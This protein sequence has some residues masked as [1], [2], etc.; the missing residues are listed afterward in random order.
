VLRKDGIAVQVKLDPVGL[1]LAKTFVQRNGWWFW[2]LITS[3]RT[4]GRYRVWHG[5]EMARRAHIRLLLSTKANSSV[6]NGR[7]LGGIFHAEM[8]LD[9]Y[10]RTEGA[11]SV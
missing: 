8:S 2:K 4:V 3:R 1:A 6:L 11:F 5:I 10:T 9:V 7:T